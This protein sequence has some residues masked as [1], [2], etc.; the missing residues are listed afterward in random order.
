MHLKLCKYRKCKFKEKC[1]FSHEGV[2]NEINYKYETFKA[3]LK[4]LEIANKKVADEN[5]RMKKVLEVT[6]KK[7]VNAEKEM[8]GLKEINENLIKDLTVLN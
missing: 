5:T 7:S 4:D 1:E 2:N 3:N 6:N 8:I